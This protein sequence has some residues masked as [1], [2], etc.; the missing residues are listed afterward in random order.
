VRAIL[1]TVMFAALLP[2]VVLDR[3]AVTVGDDAITQ[4][5][6][7]EEVRVTAFLNGDEPDL[8][9]E[10]RREAAER[11]VDQYL[12]RRDMHM[13]EFP[14]PEAS[15]AVGLLARLKQDRFLG[16]QAAYE[17]DLKHYHVTED[18]LKQ[19]LLW[20]LAALRYTDFRFRPGTPPPQEPTRAH[21]ESN[22]QVR[23]ANA[24]N[25]ADGHPPARRTEN[26]AKAEQRTQQ[27][28]VKQAL[29]SD[30]DQQLNLWLV[31][32]RSQTRIRY[33]EEAFK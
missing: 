32:A 13:T 8:S 29:P 26:A 24:A 6:V 12:I 22:E 19:H 30:V 28:A 3:I 25:A 4:Q 18:Q 17:Q 33:F 9:A 2:A 16:N 11:L 1:I 31:Q 10:G 14:Q 27:P 7:I 21:L 23:A 15:Q 20:Q 5:E